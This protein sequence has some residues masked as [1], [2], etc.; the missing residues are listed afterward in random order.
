[1]LSVHSSRDVGAEREAGWSQMLTDLVDILMVVVNTLMVELQT[2][3]SRPHRTAER[4][5]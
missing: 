4:T 2:V 3:P 5:A 1:M